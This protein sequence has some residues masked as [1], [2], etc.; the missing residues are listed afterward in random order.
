[1][2]IDGREFTVLLMLRPRPRLHLIPTAP[3][4]HPVEAEF[5]F[6][7]AAG[8]ERKELSPLA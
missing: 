6:P 5:I 3:T 2:R 1:M 7:A 4:L 8:P